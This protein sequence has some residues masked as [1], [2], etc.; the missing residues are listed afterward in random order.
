MPAVDPDR[1]HAEPLGRHVIVEQAL[2][3]VQ[4]PRARDIDPLECRLEVARV[5][6]I[7]PDRLVP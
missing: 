2:G 7:A 4:D 6:L 3:D 5:R 1:R